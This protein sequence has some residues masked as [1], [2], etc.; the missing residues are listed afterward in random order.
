VTVAN[1]RQKKF[2]IFYVPATDVSYTHIP[3]SLWSFAFRTNSL[4]TGFPL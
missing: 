3:A 2:S 1:N 4:Y